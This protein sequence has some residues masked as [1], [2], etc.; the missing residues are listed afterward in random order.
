LIDIENLTGS[1]F[2][3]KLSGD[4]DANIFNG[5]VDESNEISGDTVS[6]EDS[7]DGVTVSLAGGPGIGGD[8]AGDTYFNIENLIGSANVDTLTG[9]SSDNVLTGGAGGDTLYGG[10]DAAKGDTASYANADPATGVTAILDSG[11]WLFQ[12][13]DAAGDKFYGIENLTGSDG[14]DTLFGD[15]N[16]NTLKGGEGSD[17]LNGGAGNDTLYVTQGEDASV[18][19]GADT[20]GDTVVLQ[21]LSGTYDLTALDNIANGIEKL[22]IKDGVNTEITVSSADIQGMVNDGALSELTILTDIGVDTL[23]ITVG[24]NETLTSVDNGSYTDHTITHGVDGV[25]AQIHWQ[26]A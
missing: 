12:Q 10:A 21:G 26:I 14:D 2:D 5:G 17:T 9:D 22:N 6:Y 16:D 11:F 18:D 7:G 13:G 25:V 20:L 24:A 8:A 4:I 15:S 3:D 23:N 19:G 1:A